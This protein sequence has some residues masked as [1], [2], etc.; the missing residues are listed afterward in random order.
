MTILKYIILIILG[1]GS[2]AVISGAV[3]AFISIIGIVP[4]LAEKTKTNKYI[5]FYE[6]AI[7]A[8]GIFGVFSIVFNYYIPIG[9]IPAMFY[10]LFTGIFYGC[11]AVSL[12]EVLDVIPTLT[13]RTLLNR[14]IKYFIIAIALGKAVGAVLYYFVDGFYMF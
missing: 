5:I 2:G 1:I 6:N 11:L 4:R 3:F 13:R 9:V 8:G 10:G 7:I 12:A 14:G